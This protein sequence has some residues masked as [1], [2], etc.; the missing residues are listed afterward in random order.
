MYE[1]PLAWCGPSSLRRHG[2]RTTLGR[3]AHLQLHEAQ[4]DVAVALAG[5]AQGAQTVDDGG[6]DPD[7]AL[8]LPVELWLEAD[9]AER[10]G[11]GDRVE[12]GGASISTSRKMTSL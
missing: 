12:G 6:L 8:A 5:A 1:G 4:Y 3:D 10:Q 7:L 11:G 2:R 9:G